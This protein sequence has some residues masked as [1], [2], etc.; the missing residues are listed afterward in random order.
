MEQLY[1]LSQEKVKRGKDASGHELSS[2]V[3]AATTTK[4]H[5]MSPSLGMKSGTNQ[6]Q[7]E[8]MQML[9]LWDQFL[10]FNQTEGEN[11]SSQSNF[12]S[13]INGMPIKDIKDRVILRDKKFPS[14]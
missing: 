14:F 3:L 8:I 12:R 13:E 9:K 10:L 6:V 2:Q 5:L 4:R 7:F 11:V 1:P